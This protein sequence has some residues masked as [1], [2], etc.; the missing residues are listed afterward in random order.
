MT[1]QEA[2]ENLRSEGIKITV[3]EL[4]GKIARREIARPRLNSSL[5]FDWTLD[6]LRRAKEIL[7]QQTE[8]SA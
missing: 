2:L 3:W 6:D 7:G 4:R 8:V 1:T 5:Q